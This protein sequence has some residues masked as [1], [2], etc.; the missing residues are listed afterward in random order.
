LNTK[1]DTLIAVAGWEPRFL[2]GLRRDL[3]SYAPSELFLFKFDEYASLTQRNREQIVE[4]ASSKHVRVSEVSV[5]R[6]PATL[7]RAIRT[8]FMPNWW[9]ERTVLVDISTM[10]REVIWWVFSSLR[11]VSSRIHYVYYRP[12]AYASQWL[13]RDTD[14]PRLVYQHSGVAELGRETCLL[15]I[16]GFDVQRAAQ[17]LRFFEPQKVVIGVQTGGQFENNSRNA[18]VTRKE[19]DRV[20]NVDFFE[21]D[22][23]SEDH[24]FSAINIAIKPYL[25]NYNIVAASL[26]PKPSAV[27]LY[28]L[29]LK[30]PDIALSYAPS[31]QFSEDYSEG[32]EDEQIKGALNW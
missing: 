27:A 31:R 2:G 6:D 20:S 10:P 26:G 28:R 17:L 22:S 30:N 1:I 5:T 9:A 25:K 16:S 12:T 15:L 7:W 21:M 3:T 32:I 29:H 24:G 18:E 13:T 8:T 4:F 11:R 14:Q 19:L 23:Y